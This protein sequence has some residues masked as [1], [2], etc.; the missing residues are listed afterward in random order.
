MRQVKLGRVLSFDR[1]VQAGWID[2]LDGTE[3]INF[4]LPPAR[5]PTQ[6]SP[7]QSGQMVTFQERYG[8][9]R[10]IAVRVQAVAANVLPLPALGRTTTRH[11]ATG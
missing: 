10:R 4:T 2:P 5:P 7:I 1:S 3:W 9:D 6:S 11:K 8:L